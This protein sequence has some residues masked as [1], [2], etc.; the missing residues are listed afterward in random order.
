MKKLVMYHCNYCGKLIC[1][2][3]VP[4]R[5]PVCCDVEMSL[6]KDR[7]WDDMLVK[8]SASK[9]TDR[10]VKNEAASDKKTFERTIKVQDIDALR[11]CMRMFENVGKFCS[12]DSEQV[13]VS[14]SEIA[15]VIR[16]AALVA[17]LNSLARSQEEKDHA[18]RMTM[19]SI[20]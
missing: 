14:F 6:K 11:S 18:D 17:C 2:K 15:S 9:T 4:K 16:L 19:E 13:S 10:A 5:T 8:K 1:M 12:R 7:R 20:L 3:D